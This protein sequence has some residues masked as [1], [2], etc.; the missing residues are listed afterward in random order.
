M[1]EELE[2]GFLEAIAHDP[3]DEEAR[4]VYADW[5]EERGDPRGEY[6]RLE[7]Q[8]FQ[9]PKRLA[10]LAPSI[11]ERWLETIARRY[12]VQLCDP[13]PNKILVIKEIRTITGLGLKDAK[14][15][16][17]GATERKPH[18]IARRLER[19]IAD[20]LGHQ[21]AL[22]GA[23][24]QIVGHYGGGVLAPTEW[25]TITIRAVD[26]SHKLHAIKLVREVTDL[27]LKDAKDLVERVIAGHPEVLS[28]RQPVEVA[29]SFAQRFSA[30][31]AATIDVIEV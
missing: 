5:L 15:L 1:N 11:D 8:L 19:G 7:L 31:G 12:D 9:L 21:L 10:E 4:A 13:G 20:Q 29:R 22:V 18:T 24:Y 26:G 16:V 25:A 23:G 30:Y 2:R 3:D 28:K 27:G 14:D 17:E 6:L